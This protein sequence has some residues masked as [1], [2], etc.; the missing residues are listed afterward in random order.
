MRDQELLQHNNWTFRIFFFEK[1]K[2]NTVSAKARDDC[3][4][5]IKTGQGKDSRWK[6]QWSEHCTDHGGGTNDPSKH[7]SLFILAFCFKFGNLSCCS[8]KNFN[9]NTYM[10]TL[11]LE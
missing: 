8:A 9:L 4:K 7:D 1:K 2:T 3:V 5:L 11:A 6:Q 10:V